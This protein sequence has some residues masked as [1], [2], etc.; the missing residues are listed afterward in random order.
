MVILIPFFFLIG[1]SLSR[2]PTWPKDPT[3]M[4]EEQSGRTIGKKPAQQYYFTQE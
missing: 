4:L 3:K 1:G 2:K